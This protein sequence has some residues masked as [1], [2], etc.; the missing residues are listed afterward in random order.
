MRK[1]I[2]ILCCI[3]STSVIADDLSDRKV[4]IERME[5]K[6]SNEAQQRKLKS[7]KILVL[8]NVPINRNLPYIEDE[9]E[10][11]LRTKKEIALRALSLLVV[12]V[13]GEGLE[14]QIVEVLVKK[15][16]LKKHFSPVESAFINN[17][18]PS[19]NDRVQFTWRYEAAWTLL[20]ALGY[21]SELGV[22]A[23]ICDVPAAVTFMQERTKDQFINEA[24]LRPI[25]AIL[26]ESD[27]IYRYHWAVVD[28]RINNQS[29]PSG[30][31]P[32]VVQERHYALN[33]LIGYMGQAWDDISTDT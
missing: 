24:K 16:D 19:Q 33:W 12:A 29:V 25:G 6:I 31:N 21:V 8:Q 10:I 7:E 27:L 13:K 3:I 18:A 2:I 1:L 32:G 9:K 11:V 26:D 4:K 15:Y 30:L 14:Q 20:W 23:D 22:P 17:K 5:T 28:A